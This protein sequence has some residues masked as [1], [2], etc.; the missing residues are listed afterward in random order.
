LTHSLKTKDKGKKLR[1]EV[2]NRNE[3]ELGE[4]KS[5]KAGIKV[6]SVWLKPPL[7]K[8][9]RGAGGEFMMIQKS[10]K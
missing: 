10:K 2:T 5:R 4:A 9:E 6:R 3:V 8:Q 7:A 1:N